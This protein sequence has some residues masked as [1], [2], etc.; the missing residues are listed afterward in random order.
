M[1]RVNGERTE[2]FNVLASQFAGFV[3]KDG[4]VVTAT[5]NIDR[6]KNIVTIRG[7]VWHPGSYA[8]SNDVS[9]VKQLIDF[10]RRTA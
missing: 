4:D 2:T 1:T 7:A 3:L 8:I 10:C 5:P 9:T 6:N